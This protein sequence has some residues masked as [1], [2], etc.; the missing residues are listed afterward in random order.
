W[1]FKN[2]DSEDF[3]ISKLG[4]Y[5][6]VLTKIDFM[7]TSSQHDYVSLGSIYPNKNNE[8]IISVV[9]DIEKQKLEKIDEQL[10]LQ[11]SQIQ[12]IDTQ[13]NNSKIEIDLLE[14]QLESNE[15][16]VSVLEEQLNETKK[17]S[18]TNTTLSQIAIGIAIFSVFVAGLFGYLN[19]KK[20]Q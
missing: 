14:K 9:S 17:S 19:Y 8:Y 4:M 5:T 16:G 1:H 7:T 10:D 13:V 20:K 11:E 18:K 6:I 12:L 3:S 2:G 15:K